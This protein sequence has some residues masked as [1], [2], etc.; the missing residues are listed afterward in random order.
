MMKNQD[1]FELAKDVFLIA[2]LPACTIG[3]LAA[4]FI[5]KFT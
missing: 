4:A 3:S 5:W 2:I 1:K